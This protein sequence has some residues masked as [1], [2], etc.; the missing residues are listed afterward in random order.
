M[1]TSEKQTKWNETKKKEWEWMY[2]KW[3]TKKEKYTVW[4]KVS[5][6]NEK[7]MRKI[8]NKKKYILGW[9]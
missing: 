7:K 9:K 5:L 4:N 1:W 2:V 3:N 6:K 8:E